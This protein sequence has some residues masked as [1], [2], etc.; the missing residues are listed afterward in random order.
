MRKIYC[1]HTR[2]DVHPKGINSCVVCKIAWVNGQE[3]PRIILG[4]LD[5]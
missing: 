3:I 4:Y 2:I 5:D 1:A